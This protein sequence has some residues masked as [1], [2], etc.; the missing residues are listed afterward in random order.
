LCF[1]YARASRHDSVTH[2]TN[3]LAIFCWYRSKSQYA[4]DRRWRHFKS[5]PPAFCATANRAVKQSDSGIKAN[6]S[7]WLGE[8]GID[9]EWQEG[10]GAFSVSASN[11]AAVKAY[12]EEQERHH[13]RRNFE[14]E[15]TVMLKKAGKA[16]D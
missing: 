2:T 6:S 9:F 16:H 10:Y 1:F 5:R 4:G 12:I 15:F 3:A 13:A 8:H 14:D 11:T 7:R